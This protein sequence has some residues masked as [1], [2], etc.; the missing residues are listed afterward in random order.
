MLNSS[1]N[2]SLWNSISWSLTHIGTDAGHSTCITRAPVLR[3]PRLLCSYG[4]T[5]STWG[6][7]F[8]DVNGKESRENFIWNFYSVNSRATFVIQLIFLEGVMWFLQ[9]QGTWEIRSSTGPRR[10]GESDT[11]N[12][13]EWLPQLNSREP[14]NVAKMA[15]YVEFTCCTLR[16]PFILSRLQ[17]CG[18]GSSQLVL[19]CTKIWE[20][21]DIWWCHKFYYCEFLKTLTTFDEVNEIMR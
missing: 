1:K 20:P 10:K 5:V 6:P 17:L 15:F 7:C 8:H 11:G 14:T 18:M 19:T 12:P 16:G 9:P 21:D 4:S 3:Q 2:L 13:W